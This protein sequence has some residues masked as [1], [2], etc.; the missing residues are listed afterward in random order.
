MRKSEHPS[1]E[2]TD[3]ITQSH[4]AKKYAIYPAQLT[5]PPNNQSKQGR[6]SL[7]ASE[8]VGL[9]RHGSP[10][11]RSQSRMEEEEQTR[12]DEW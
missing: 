4:I 7:P 2:D 1:K 3:P 10:L 8:E 11:R 5:G 9:C 12:E 6:A